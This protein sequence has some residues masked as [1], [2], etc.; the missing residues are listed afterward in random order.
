MVP[1]FPNRSVRLSVPCALAAV[2][3]RVTS[4][5]RLVMMNA[6]RAS[7]AR[8]ESSSSKGLFSINTLPVCSVTLLINQGL[9]R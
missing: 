8:T 7:M 6:L 9:V 1:V 4:C 5:N 2:P 3:E